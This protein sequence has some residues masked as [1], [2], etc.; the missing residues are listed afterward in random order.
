LEQDFL[1]LLW[2]VEFDKPCSQTGFIV[3]LPCNIVNYSVNKLPQKWPQNEKM[4][5][6]TYR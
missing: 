3:F 5:T 4:R 2:H 6:N 1:T